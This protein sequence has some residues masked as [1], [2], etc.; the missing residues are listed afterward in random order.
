MVAGVVEV[1]LGLVSVSV[2]LQAVAPSKASK[3]GELSVT[4]AVPLMIRGC[5]IP[6]PEAG[7]IRS[8]GF[9]YHSEA[10]LAGW[11]PLTTS[12]VML[13]GA[14]VCVALHAAEAE[15]VIAP[16]LVEPTVYAV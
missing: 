14:K 13:Y 15:V 4:S 6:L 12:S 3:T 9:K 8:S 5:R 10:G 16:G 11:L 2:P 7:I 1:I